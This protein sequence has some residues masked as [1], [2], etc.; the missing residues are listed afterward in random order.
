MLSRLREMIH[1]R[2]HRKNLYSTAAYWD[3]KAHSFED[4]A[5]SMWPNRVLNG[6]Y[7]REQEELASRYLGEIE[8]SVLLDLG[9]GTGRFSRRLAN[10][11]AR[12]TG[13]D[14]ST[15]ALAIAKRLSSGNNPTYRRGSVFELS[16]E[17]AYDVIFTW[18]V[19]TVACLDKN[20]LVDVLIRIRKALRPAGRLLLTEPIHR[21]FLHRVLALDL[22]EFLSAMQQAGFEIKA[23]DP[24]HFWPMR[25]AL[26][27]ISWPAWLTVPLYH[28]G[29][30]AMKVP[31]LSRLGDYWAILA[32]VKR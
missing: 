19:L 21:G 29:Q 28:L 9:C 2:R 14:F 1:Q 30:A 26:C 32:C 5:V 23:T 17:G 15:G 20:Q 11:G 22:P 3:S 25:L 13:L 24:L 8:G 6:L 16:D 7:E 10:K 27:Y 18:G 12:V 31:G 4:T